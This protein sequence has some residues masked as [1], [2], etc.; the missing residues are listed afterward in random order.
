MSEQEYLDLMEFYFKK[1]G[2]CEFN[3][4]KSYIL[5]VDEDDKLLLLFGSALFG[6]LGMQLRNYM[7]NTRPDIDKEFPEYDKFEDYSWELFL[8]IVDKWKNS[9]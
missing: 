6:R 9:N 3:E 5:K 2:E 7:R 4:W 8:K 1:D